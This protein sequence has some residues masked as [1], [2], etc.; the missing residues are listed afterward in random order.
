MLAT[1]MRP[2]SHLEKRMSERAEDLRD[3]GITPP[4]AATQ[5][6]EERVKRRVRDE[7]CG[8]GCGGVMAAGEVRRLERR[9]AEGRQEVEDVERAVI[10]FGSVGT[11]RVKPG[12]E[13]ASQ[14]EKEKLREGVIIL[15]GVK[16]FL[17]SVMQYL[18][19]SGFVRDEPENL[20]TSLQTLYEGALS[21]ALYGGTGKQAWTLQHSALSSRWAL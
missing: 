5:V 19:P 14:R 12:V 9:C 18:V 13:I 20:E 16:R 4:Q 10:V 21:Q 7:R 8:C 1:G 15:G 11:K 6:L 3:F 2:W 17:K